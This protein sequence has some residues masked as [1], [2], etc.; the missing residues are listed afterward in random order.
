[1]PNDALL[2]PGARVLVL[3]SGKAG[4]QANC[5]GVAAALGAGYV[6]RVVAPR[7]L[8]AGLAPYGPLDP[9]DRPGRA[10]SPLARPFPDIA[11]ACGRV[12]VPYIRALKRAGGDAVFAVFLQDP[13][14]S[15]AAMDLIW[16]PEHDELAGSNVV[17]TLTSPHPFSA[18]RL[19][20][21]RAA[22]DPRIAAL[23]APR[24]AI[25][26]GGPSGAHDFAGG[27]VER[28]A[29]AASSLA[30]A[31]YSVMATPSRRTPPELVAAV[32]RGLGAAPAF[33][34]DG[35][36]DN[37]YAQILANAE[38]ILVTGD[39]VNMVGEATATGAPVYVFEPSGGGGKIGRYLDALERLG[40]VRRFA[41]RFEPFAYAPIDSSI[42][43]AREIA[44][45]YAAA[46]TGAARH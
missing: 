40:A 6:L 27:D 26:L 41:G 44:R 38:T 8:F 31:G 39:S 25:V 34:W 23:P 32:R 17:A 15:R 7:P 9:R 4:H 12:T 37:P 43:V 5:L 35:A 14:A 1:L 11:I 16:T 42:V 29:A 21:A 13:R 18:A 30:R 33:V 46:R 22:P 36:G 24:A 10:G 3:G 28:L 19:A 2:P 20:A 45:R